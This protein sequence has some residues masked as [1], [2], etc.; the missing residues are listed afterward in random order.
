MHAIEQF[1]N[2]TK[3]WINYDKHLLLTTEAH[4]DYNTF[5]SEFTTMYSVFYTLETLY[6]TR[7]GH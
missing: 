2:E 1:Q 4:K 7:G 6:D 5:Y 3:L